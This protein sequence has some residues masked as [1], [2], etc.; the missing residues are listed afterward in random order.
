MF[1]CGGVGASV[2]QG[3]RLAGARQIIAIDLLASK[4][5]SARH[6]GATHTILPADES[7]VRQIKKLSGGGVD[8]AFDAVGNVDLA[9][10]CICSVAPRGTAVIVVAIP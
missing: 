2:I 6:F 1:G 4:L 5:E 9:A 3:A 10:S 7:V 8:F